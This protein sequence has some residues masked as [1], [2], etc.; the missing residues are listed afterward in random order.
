MKTVIETRGLTKK[1]GARTVLAKVD[2]DV[3]A[4]SIYAYL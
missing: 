2:M 4:G 3:P 1:F